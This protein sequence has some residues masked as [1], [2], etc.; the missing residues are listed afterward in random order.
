MGITHTKDRLVTV[1][2]GLPLEGPGFEI[3]TFMKS[4]MS[5]GYFGI[6]SQRCIRS[7]KAG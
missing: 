4:K 7:L 1:A 3:P 2:R 6:E 5:S